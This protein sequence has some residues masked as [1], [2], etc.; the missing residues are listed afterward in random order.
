MRKINQLFLLLLIL[1]ISIFSEQCDKYTGTPTR[2][3]DCLNQLSDE[4]KK[5]LKKTHCC[6]FQSDNQLDPKC[7]SLTETQYDNID[8]FIEYNEILWGYV[9]VKIN[10]NSF[11]YKCGI[12]YV[13]LFLF[14]I[15]T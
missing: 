11:Y 10:C 2:V 6:F 5:D 3:D 4:Q 8:D 7:I 14:I 1:L 9:N 12:F 15:F 13:V